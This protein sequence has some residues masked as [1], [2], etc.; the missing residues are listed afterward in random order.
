MSALANAFH[1]VGN[2]EERLRLHE[3]ELAWEQ[4]PENGVSQTDILITLGNIAGCLSELGRYKESLDMGRE[5]YDR[6]RALSEWLPPDSI[7]ITVQGLTNQMC[8]LGLFDEC[9]EFA[10]ERIPEAERALGPE[11]ALTLC[12][13]NSYAV[14]LLN[15]SN[16]TLDDMRLGV[17]T[18][19]GSLKTTRRVMG[20]SH[21]RTSE[22]EG[23]LE[24]ARTTLAAEEARTGLAVL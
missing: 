8:G 14:A 2:H 11:N 19:E 10:R 16:A 1:D 13:R 17:E 7:F 4:R 20:T 24:H 21:P 22:C 6:K 23:F 9:K 18:L 5:I 3:A 12:I 15:S